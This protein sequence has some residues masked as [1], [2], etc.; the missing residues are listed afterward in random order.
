[1]ADF[2]PSALGTKEHWDNT[3]EVELEN[4]KSH[5][6]EG[7]IWFGEKVQR[8][9]VQYFINKIESKS[10]CI[11]DIGCGNG[12]LLRQL[13][14][15]GGFS[16]LKGF[17]YSE[18]AIQLAKNIAKAGNELESKIDLFVGDFLDGSFAHRCGIALDKV[19][20]TCFFPL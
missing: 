5:E 4:F 19:I 14:N 18:N 16:N 20:S 2:G 3:Y 1:M 17:D 15:K 7:E 6:E 13:A 9:V 11:M 10:V 8:E 12:V